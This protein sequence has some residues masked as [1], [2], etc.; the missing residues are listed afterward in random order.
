MNASVSLERRL[1]LALMR[2][3][4]RLLPASRSEWAKAMQAEIA[5]VQNDRDALAWAIGCIVAGS[6]ERID[7]MLGDKLK[8]SRWIFVLEM[9]LCFVPLTLGW[10][11]A[12]GGGA[13]I[14]RLN[15]EVI[16]KEF[17]LTPDGALVLVA[18]IA[19]AVLGTLGPLGLATAF[20][21]LISGR[22]PGSR[23]LR[24]ALVAGPAVYG[25][26]LL[27]VRLATGGA[28]ALSFN[29]VDSFDFWSGILLLSVLPSLGATHL[30]RIA[31]Q[32]ETSRRSGANS[33]PPCAVGSNTPLW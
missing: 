2:R 26:L 16:H 21:L 24:T 22:A 28:G 32:D 19:G 3:V 30:L 7:S 15:A 6:K 1:A 11:D 8:I 31:S 14:L 10:L 12:L 23:W 25:V 5:H 17:L 33:G 27:A 4:D 9:L 20:R 29:T 13:R 18:L